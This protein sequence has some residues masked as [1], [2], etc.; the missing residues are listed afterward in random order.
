MN[1]DPKIL[2]DLA[3]VFAEAVLNDLEERSASILA[4]IPD[5]K[6][7]DLDNFHDS[8]GESRREEDQSIE[9]QCRPQHTGGVCASV[10]SDSEIA[11]RPLSFSNSR[12]FNK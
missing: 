1:L 5:K 3:S 6:S 7:C 11:A 2:D 10:T 12:R 8:R 9:P 4:G